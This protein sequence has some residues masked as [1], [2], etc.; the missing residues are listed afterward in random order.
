MINE[1][2]TTKYHIPSNGIYLYARTNKGKNELIIVNSK[3]AEQTLASSHY[4]MLTS[5]SRIG[6]ELVTGKEIDL[7][8]DMLLPARQSLIIEF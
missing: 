3:N 1:T 2:K 4:S 7:T 5:Q 6:K 8:K